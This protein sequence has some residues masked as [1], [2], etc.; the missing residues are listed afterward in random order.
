MTWMIYGANGYNGELIAREAGGKWFFPLPAGPH[1]RAG[2]PPAQDHS[3]PCQAPQAAAAELY[4][5]RAVLHCAG[6]FVHTSRPMV[7]ACLATGASYLD[8]TGEIAVFE[9]SPGR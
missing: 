4:G 1:T 7:A 8:I 2:G 5:V 3:P 9:T 6:P